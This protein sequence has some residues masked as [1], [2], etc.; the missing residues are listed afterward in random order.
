MSKKLTFILELFDKT[1]DKLKRASSGFNKVND[2]AKKTQTQINLLPHSIHSLENRLVLL[3]EK[4]KGAFTTQGIRHYQKEIDVTE[5]KLKKLNISKSGGGL[6]QIGAEVSSQMPMLG[7]MGAAMASPVGIGVAAA[8]LVGKTLYSATDKAM[9]FEKGM[10]KVNG[11]LQLSPDKLKQVRNQ[12]IQLGSNSSTKLNEIPDAFYKIASATGGDLPTSMKI[13]KSSLKGAEAGFADINQVADATVNIVNSVGKANTDANEVM[14]VLF[15]T[16]NK[17]KTEFSDIANYLPK[18]IPISKNL[19]TSFKETAGAFA[20]LTANGLK[21]EASTTALQNVFKSFSNE[22]TRDNFKALGVTIFDANDKMRNITDISKELNLSLAG[23]TD[24]KRIEKLES[25]GLDQEAA[26][27][28]SIMAANAN[29]LKTTIDYVALSGGEMNRTLE[30]SSN[31]LTK[32][33]KLGNQFQGMMIKLGYAILPVV[34]NVLETILNW[35]KSLTDGISSV[36]EKS[37]MFRDTIKGIGFAIKL[38]FSLI[39]DGIKLIGQAFLLLGSQFGITKDSI[40][41]LFKGINDFYANTKNKLTSIGRGFMAVFKLIKEAWDGIWNRDF[42][43]FKKLSMSNLRNA[44]NEASKNEEIKV[45]VRVP[46]YIKTFAGIIKKTKTPNNPVL[47]NPLGKGLSD[48]ISSVTEGGKQQ[49]NITIN[50]GK[51]QD[52]INIYSENITE[53]VNEMQDAVENALLRI[54]NSANSLV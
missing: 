11:T 12:L 19:G 41:G 40:T 35:T 8:A 49:K 33:S 13:M 43:A 21:A 4:Q 36:W 15:A 51:F 50:L 30:K 48:G 25:L 17:G 42:S 24:K 7:G 5:K 18:L 23:L 27:G 6:K 10:A 31:P 53:G 26:L 22:K 45:P 44:F 9:N 54:L 16:L 52:S 3:R 2:S 20:F 14:D 34:N 29:E 38:P 46:K 32:I 1:G 39:F 47:D 37:E 28:V